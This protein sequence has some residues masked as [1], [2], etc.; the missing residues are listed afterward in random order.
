MATMLIF[1]P[2]QRET[3]IVDLDARPWLADVEFALGGPVD[4]VPGFFSIQYDGAVHRCAAFALRNRASRSLNVAATIAWDG[5]LRREMG[6]GLIR[7]DGTRAGHLAGPV[8]V[9]VR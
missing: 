8:A 6:V 2:H 1:H 3:R 4:K 7:R 5:A 9:V